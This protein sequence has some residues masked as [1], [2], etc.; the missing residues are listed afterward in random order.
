MPRHC[1][2]TTG[3]FVSVDP[4]VRQTMEPY[5]YG[6]AS[7]VTKSDPAGLCTQFFVDGNWVRTFYPSG[8]EPISVDNYGGSRNQGIVIC[9]VDEGELPIDF[10]FGSGKPDEYVGVP[11]TLLPYKPA[12]DTGGW[13]WDRRRGIPQIESVTAGATWL[14]VT[15]GA[16]GPV[17]GGLLA[18]TSCNPPMTI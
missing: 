8:G 13:L 12:A 15:L 17:L 10:E 9:S 16:C 4:L 18:R 7:P 1:D 11:T 5:V 14:F 6:S 3:V 2:P